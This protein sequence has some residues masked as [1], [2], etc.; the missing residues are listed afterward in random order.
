MPHWAI[1]KEKEE[2]EELFRVLFVQLVFSCESPPIRGWQQ[3]KKEKG[4]NLLPTHARKSQFV[5]TQLLSGFR[6]SFPEIRQAK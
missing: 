3:K 1:A 6:T 2:A 5:T 4:H